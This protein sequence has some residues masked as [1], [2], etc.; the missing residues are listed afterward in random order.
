MRIGQPQSE[1]NRPGQDTWISPD[2]ALG[3]DPSNMTAAPPP[4]DAPAPTTQRL[5][6]PLSYQARNPK[7]RKGF[8]RFGDWFTGAVQRRRW[9]QHVLRAQARKVVE[10][11]ESF[12]NHSERAFDLEV[13][14]AREAARRGRRDPES[15]THAFAVVR[16]AVRRTVGLG[17]YPEQVMGG[18]VMEDGCIA[19]MATGEGKT[20]TACLTAAVQ[21]WMGYGVHVVTVNDYL[22]RR[23]AELNEPVYRRLGLSVGAI[24][25]TS[26][27][28]Q[29]REAYACDVTYTSDQ[30]LIF[31][32]L[33]DRLKAPLQP[34]VVSLLLEEVSDTNPN[35]RSQLWTERLVMRGQYAAII[36]EADSVLVDQ[37][38]TPA[39][40]GVEGGEDVAADYYRVAAELAQEL[41]RGA[42]YEVDVRQH[43]VDIN[44]D[45]LEKLSE[46]ADKLPP[47][48]AGPRR[49][50][51]LVTQALVAAELFHRE[52][53][54]IVQ[55]D[56]VKIVDIHTGRVLEGRQ[57]QLGLHQAVQA[58]ESIP[59][60]SPRHTMARMS[61]QRFFQLYR[62]LAGMTGTAWEVRN[63]LWKTYQLPVVR[64]PTH[65]PVIRVHRRDRLCP[66]QTAKFKA[67]ADRV[68][69]HHK[70]LRPVL[71]GTRSVD[72]SELMSQLLTE[73]NIPHNV[74]NAV[75]HEQEA[76]I[77]A[78][79]GK[80]G[81][82]TVAT[83]M[84]G[85]GTD[86]ILA[87]GVPEL[88]GLVVI[89]TERHD[90]RRVDRQLFG[91][92]GRQGD[93]GLAE[94]FV[95]LDD[96]LIKTAGIRILARL[97]KAV[98]SLSVFGL[99][100]LLWQQAQFAASRRQAV[101][102]EM[103]AKSDQWFDRALYYHS[104]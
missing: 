101:S 16:E 41:K 84:A 58:K 76:T 57:W 77:V 60:T 90:A 11:S 1:R 93:P 6:R 96:Q 46:L 55:D 15:R 40:I 39:I 30:Q 80:K 4:D 26:E 99:H 82:V 103:V 32:F 56:D 61:Y 37:A 72:A 25:D 52:D 23:D 91:R 31:D 67:V 83:N 36:D 29:R 95:S 53:H 42:H 27:E 89:A 12:H 48:W 68:E 43:R 28:E 35:P 20:V 8:D 47:F 7:E 13:E 54:Y 50:E 85:R 51:E 14:T 44:D 98:P 79:A 3:S 21:A 17:L 9:K 45:G 66:D 33:R 104:R 69:R 22:A 73:R 87:R 65:K 78:T 19:E 92:S 74:L 59:I 81:A 2:Q 102:R 38:T 86:I 100:R 63:E 75:R 18:W 5:W 97:L 24:Q 88:G 94:T 64:I 34:R 62:R 70:I 71:I 49:R 10:L